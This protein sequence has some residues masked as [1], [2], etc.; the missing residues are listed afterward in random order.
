M[1]KNLTQQSRDMLML[2]PEADGKMA[3]A[4][5]IPRIA[6]ISSYGESCNFCL[7]RDYKKVYKIDGN[8]LSIR[9]CE[10]CLQIIK[11]VTKPNA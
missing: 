8:S 3:K 1:H 5:L 9:I 2:S 11:E 10:G 6:K 4:G 7:D